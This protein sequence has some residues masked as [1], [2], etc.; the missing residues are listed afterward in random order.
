MAFIKSSNAFQSTV[1][2]TRKKEN[3][4]KL[5]GLRKIRKLEQKGALDGKTRRDAVKGITMR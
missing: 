1:E 2:E 5:F 4:Q 3:V